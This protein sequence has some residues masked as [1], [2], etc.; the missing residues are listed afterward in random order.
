MKTKK[1]KK[2]PPFRSEEEERKFWAT[3]DVT[4]FINPAKGFWGIAAERYTTKTRSVSI[5]LPETLLANLKR[6]AQAK[7][8]AYQ[9]LIKV[10]LSERINQ[11][12]M[13]Q[14]RVR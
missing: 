7:D 2:A 1:Q 8:V 10:W 12:K 13:I 14:S 3:H 4:E 11:E 5:R 9:A 6:L